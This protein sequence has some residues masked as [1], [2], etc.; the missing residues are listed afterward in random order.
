MPGLC[1]ATNH[2]CVFNAHAVAAK[3]LP[4]SSAR[5]QVDDKQQDYRAN[6]CGDQEA[7]RAAHGETE[8]RQQPAAQKTT[9]DADD[10]VED[11][12]LGAIALHHDTGQPA[13]YAANNQ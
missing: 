13:R 3:S 2:G 11:D 1:G 6:E 5:K 4:R 7:K 9:D 12:A 10:H 8:L